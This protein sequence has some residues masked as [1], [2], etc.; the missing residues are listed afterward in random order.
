[1]QILRGI[2][3]RICFREYLW[4][5]HLHREWKVVQVGRT[6]GSMTGFAAPMRI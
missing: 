5:Q 3:F 4:D 6:E 1:M 2:V